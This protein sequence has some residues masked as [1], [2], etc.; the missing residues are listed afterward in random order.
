MRVDR[1]FSVSTLFMVVIEEYCLACRVV[2]YSL[3]IYFNTKEQRSHLF[4]A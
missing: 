3:R 4:I 2:D 1:L